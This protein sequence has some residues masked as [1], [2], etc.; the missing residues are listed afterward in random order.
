MDCPQTTLAVD[1]EMTCT[2]DVEGT[3]VTTTNIAMAEGIAGYVFDGVLIGTTDRAT[4]TVVGTTDDA[5][6]TVAPDGGVEGETDVPEAPQTDAINS[7][8]DAGNTLPILL[9]VL[10]IIGLAAVVLTPAR[11]RRR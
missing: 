3:V 8:G 5:T 9:A 7:S 10:G 1:E 4:V 6:V 2:A 11:A